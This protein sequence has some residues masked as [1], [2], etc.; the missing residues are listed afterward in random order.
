MNLKKH[1]I[2]SIL[3]FI[4]FSFDASSQFSISQ[5]DTLHISDTN[6][7]WVLFNF[8]ISSVKNS[9]CQNYDNCL[10]NLPK[11]I[12]NQ[13]DFNDS[14]ELVF[15]QNKDF[16]YTIKSVGRGALKFKS[17][18]PKNKILNIKNNE[19]KYLFSIKIAVDFLLEKIIYDSTHKS[20]TYMLVRYHIDID[21]NT[22]GNCLECLQFYGAKS[23][24]PTLVIIDKTMP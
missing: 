7:R 24:N 14:F 23:V 22:I 2:L 9:K 11:K 20:S 13:K 3:I 18:Y 19:K 16:P 21:H 1:K 15:W 5:V 17:S 12:H 8:W 4:I 10:L 6:K